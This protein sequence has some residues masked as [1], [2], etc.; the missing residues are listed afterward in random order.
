MSLQEAEEPSADTSPKSEES[1]ADE[2][3]VSTG[4]DVMVM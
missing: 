4:E 2:S 1:E 3:K